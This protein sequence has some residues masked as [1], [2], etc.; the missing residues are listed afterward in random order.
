MAAA[1]AVKGIQ[2]GPVTY[3]A[4]PRVKEKCRTLVLSRVVN[5]HRDEKLVSDI[6]R[7]GWEGGRKNRSEKKNHQ[8]QENIKKK[9]PYHQDQDRKLLQRVDFVRLFIVLFT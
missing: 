5:T 8:K 9:I 4:G 2:E 3:Y 1:A 7:F 6:F